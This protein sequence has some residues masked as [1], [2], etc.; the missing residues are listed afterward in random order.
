MI[1]SLTPQGMADFLEFARIDK[2]TDMGNSIVHE[3][4]IGTPDNPCRFV[5]INDCHGKTIL[6]M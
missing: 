4:D 5:L 3:G 6:N 1:Q 2:T